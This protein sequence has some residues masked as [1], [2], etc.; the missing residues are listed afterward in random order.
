MHE[1]RPD[2]ASRPRILLV[3]RNFPP[4]HG[5]MERLIRHCYE[6]LSSEFELALVGP[7]GCA[8]LPGINP[9]TTLECP[10]RPTIWSL[11]RFQ[12]AAWRMACRFRPDIVISGSG[13]MA[14]AALFAARSV[15]AAVI[16]YVHGLDLI[17]DS[18]IYQWL[19][20]GALRRLDLLLANSRNTR[21]LADDVT[22]LGHR[23]H[24][25]HPGVSLVPLPTT[26]IAATFRRRHSLDERTPILLSVGRLTPRKG[27]AEFVEHALPY[28][29]KELPGC[30]LVIIGSEPDHALKKNAGE[31]ARIM[32]AATTH[33]LTKNLLFLGSADDGTLHDTMAAADIMVFP[34]LDLPGD[35]EGFGMVA[36]EASASGLPTIAFAAGG[37]PDAIEHGVSGHL[38]PPGDYRLFAETVIQH[39]DQHKTST[40]REQCRTFASAFSWDKFGEKL[41]SFCRDVLAQR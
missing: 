37:V 33:G 24:V 20:I 10:L 23:I 25:I 28:V 32:A 34:V 19:F 12:Y 27:L 1:S 14:P 31:T 39:I 29:V 16:S 3:T 2:G 9:A 17:A 36:L 30:V 38:I 26:N 11:I 5:G 15:K 22:G 6:E 35:V 40:Q 41:R 18:R 21:Q 7:P 13:V 8:S 4:T